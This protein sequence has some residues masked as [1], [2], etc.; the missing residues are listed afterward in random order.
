LTLF[1]VWSAAMEEPQAKTTTEIL[2][3]RVRMTR[4]GPGGVTPFE[5]WLALRRQILVRWR[6]SA[7]IDQAAL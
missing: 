3:L 6:K 7:S 1:E 5:R 2:T 4:L